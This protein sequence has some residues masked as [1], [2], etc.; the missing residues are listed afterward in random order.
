MKQVRVVVINCRENSR[1]AAFGRDSDAV[2]T[3][4]TE[5]G[6]APEILCLP[7]ISGL[8]LHD[9]AALLS[10]TGMLSELL[11]RGEWYYPFV[12]IRTATTNP[13]GLWVSTSQIKATTDRQPKYPKDP[14]ARYLSNPLHRNLV[15]AVIAGH[16]VWL[17]PIRW[18]WRSV[19]D[20]AVR[21]PTSVDTELATVPA[22]LLGDFAAPLDTARSDQT[23]YTYGTNTEALRSLLKNGFWD[24]GHADAEHDPNRASDA[25][26][27][28]E[29]ILISRATPARLQPGS[30]HIGP[31][32]ARP[33]YTGVACTLNF[34]A[35]PQRN[36]RTI[37]SHKKTTDTT[38]QDRSDAW[39]DTAKDE[40]VS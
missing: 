3:V 40:E 1:L 25:E 28:T 38:N 27:V 17:K 32:W 30:F 35:P 5:M 4:V 29:H 20:Y 6:S 36:T 26:L 16:Q 31:D 2:V 19:N 37:R 10:L 23:W 22:L 7:S 15:E 34:D 18:P 21:R 9:S 14:H 11:P 24:A 8:G 12:D 33:H 13:P 39:P